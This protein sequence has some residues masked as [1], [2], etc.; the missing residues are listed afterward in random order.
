MVTR[1]RVARVLRAVAALAG[2]WA[3]VALVT[4]GVRFELGTLLISSRNPVRPATLAILLLAGAGW[5]DRRSLGGVLSR[6]P[7]LTGRLAQWV[8]PLAAGA[9]LAVSVA[10]G[11]RAAIAADQ[12]GYVSQSILWR[13]GD[14]RLR[15]PLAEQ[16]PGPMPSTPSPRSAIA[17]SI[18]GRS[19]RFIRQAFRCSWRPLGPFQPVHHSSSCPCALRF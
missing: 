14:L 5:L 7:R 2:A 12:F 1:S 8:A 10:Y 6:A 15:V 3:F 13:H 16:M 4:G 18:R 11:G 19:S 9:I 17:P